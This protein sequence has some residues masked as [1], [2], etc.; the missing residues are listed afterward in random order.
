MLQLR[1]DILESNKKIMFIF[2]LIGVLATIFFVFCVSC[3]F[4]SGFFPASEEEAEAFN[5]WKEKQLQKRLQYE[6]SRR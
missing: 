2:T 4:L 1:E 5:A 6:S 3:V